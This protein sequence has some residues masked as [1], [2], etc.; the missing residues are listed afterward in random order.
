MRTANILLKTDTNPQ[1]IFITTFTEAGVIAIRE[2][3][4]SF[5]GEEAYKVNISTIHSFASE[6]IKTFPE[7][8]IEYKASTTIDDVEAL[9]IIKEILD[10]LI[11]EKSVVELTN[12]YD[13]YYYLRDIK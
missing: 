10:N 6:V 7:K 5:I 12:D 11:K 8:F 13:K 2:R 4:I 9:E 3:L 1:N